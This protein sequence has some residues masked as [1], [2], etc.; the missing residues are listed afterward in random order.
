LFLATELPATVSGKQLRIGEWFDESGVY[1][2]NRNWKLTNWPAIGSVL[3]LHRYNDEQRQTL[4]A[5][6]KSGTIKLVKLT[7][8]S[9]SDGV[10]DEGI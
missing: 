6:L 7:H 3:P 9:T 8:T 2:K 5:S 4:L 10:S 1:R